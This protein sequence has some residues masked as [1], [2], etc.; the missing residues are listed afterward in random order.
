MSEDRKRPPSNSSWP[1]MMRSVAPYLNI[2]WIFLVT[3]GLGLL[4][5][6]WVDKRFETE[7]WFFLVGA[8]LGIAVGFYHFF[9][10]VL[11]L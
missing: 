4:A 9:K 1:E 11:R 3:L 7:P 5:G 6:Y 2:G 10:T 8:L